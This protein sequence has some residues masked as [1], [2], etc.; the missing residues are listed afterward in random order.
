MWRVKVRF[1]S[2]LYC[3]VIYESTQLA[4]VWYPQNDAIK[5]IK[6]YSNAFSVSAEAATFSRTLHTKKMHKLIK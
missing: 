3:F 5:V 1:I 4:T 6:E 2:W